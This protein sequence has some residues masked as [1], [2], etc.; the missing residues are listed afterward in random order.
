[1]QEAA[2]KWPEPSLFT[3][4]IGRKG[5]AKLWDAILGSKHVQVLLFYSSFVLLKYLFSSIECWI[6]AWN[7]SH[8]VLKKVQSSVF[9]RPKLT[10]I[11]TYNQSPVVYWLASA[12]HRGDY[13]C[14][15]ICREIECR[16]GII[17]SYGGSFFK[18]HII[19]IKVCWAKVGRTNAVRTNESFRTHVGW[20]TCKGM[21]YSATIKFQRNCGNINSLFFVKIWSRASF[22]ICTRFLFNANIREIKKGVLKD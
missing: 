1:V 13:V 20:S 17:G 9:I 21:F 2:N 7:C 10:K 19:V 5:E 8:F 6:Y 22:C 4:Q 16:Q 3:G 12:C 14:R 11:V 18:K 15:T